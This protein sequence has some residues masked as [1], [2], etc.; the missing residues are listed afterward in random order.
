MSQRKV[1]EEEEEEGEKE[2]EKEEEAEHKVRE[3]GTYWAAAFWFVLFHWLL[4]CLLG[5]FRL[6]DTRKQQ[7]RT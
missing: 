6:C 1:E 3:G 5:W 7:L 2:G 4:L